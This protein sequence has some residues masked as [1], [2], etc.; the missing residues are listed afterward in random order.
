MGLFDFMKNGVAVDLEKTV[1]RKMSGEALD[2]RGQP[3]NDD[4]YPLHL[5]AFGSGEDTEVDTSSHR[6]KTC[7]YTLKEIRAD[8]KKMGKS[9][10][11]LTPNLFRLSF[12]LVDGRRIAFDAKFRLEK[13]YIDHGRSREF[14]I[15]LRDNV[16]DNAVNLDESAVSRLLDGKYAAE[17]LPE[18]LMISG[19][20]TVTDA[21]EEPEA[22][23]SRGERVEDFAPGYLAMGQFRIVREVGGGGQGSAYL[24]INEMEQVEASKRVVLKV[25]RD[26]DVRSREQLAREAETLHD[27]RHD[28]IAPFVTLRAVGD[29]PVLV[30]GY[31]E[32]RPLST[33]LAERENCTLDEAE[34]R[35][36]LR[37]IARALDYAHG[38]GTYHLD[39]DPRNII[40]RKTP[41]MGSR[42]CLIDFG[43]ARRK[44]A[45][46]STTQSTAVSGKRPYMSPEHWRGENPS[47]AMDVY[48]LAVTA[49]ECL[50]GKLPY[51]EGWKSD[52]HVDEI[53]PRT[54][55]TRAVM[56]G[57]DWSPKNRPTTCAQLIDPPVDVLPPPED[58][59][60]NP[61]GFQAES[62][63]H[64]Q[65]VKP[66]ASLREAFADVFKCY[67]V[68]CSKSAGRFGMTDPDLSAWFAERQRELRDLT[69]SDEMCDEEALKRF[70]VVVTNRLQMTGKTAGEFFDPGE[71]YQIGQLK[72]KLRELAKTHEWRALCEA[73]D[74]S[75]FDP[76]NEWNWR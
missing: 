12:D 47:V 62:G 18:W 37:P 51:P 42:T 55:F 69:A 25:L 76:H 16:K 52:V 57:L 2:Y 31:I 14:G 7:P 5:Y 72:I 40:V 41:R 60:K 49:Y 64:L 39:I 35:E 63:Q 36:L 66:R 50:M 70:F 23:N 59:Q 6:L 33:Y 53:T 73:I 75:L 38:R 48:S 32:G 3:I 11:Y 8:V 13:G 34:T 58:D 19:D 1:A 28:N 61:H 21:P 44:H 30:M 9:V 20:V 43:I 29:I 45:D 17:H 4:G 74:D 68:L 56:R 27:L 26:C 22:G 15:W 71:Y 10:Y 65:R 54:P 46:G 67:R 24:A